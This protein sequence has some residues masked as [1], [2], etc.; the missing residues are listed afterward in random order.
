M[1][2][3]YPSKGAP[4]PADAGP[5]KE[6]LAVEALQALAELK[7]KTRH[8]FVA[9]SGGKDSIVAGHLAA[10]LDVN[11]AVRETSFNFPTAD[12]EYRRCGEEV[13][14]N[15]AEVRGC[16]EAWLATHPEWVFGP[17]RKLGGFYAVRQQA[18]VRRFA[19][20]RAMEGVVFGRRTQENTVPSALYMKAGIWQCHPLRD[21]R[22]SDVWAYI[23][24]RG[25]SYPGIYD[26]Q[27]GDYSGAA[28]WNTL[29]R[30]WLARVSD[31]RHTPE[32]LI[33]DYEPGFLE[34]IRWIIDAAEV[35]RV[36][37]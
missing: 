25:L 19:D 8:S 33:E 22:T 14:L 13:G 17:V 32:G 10:V 31:D 37:A 21:W 11:L 3:P 28:S 36:A 15:V 34:E 20:E 24:S 26:R 5:F 7:R 29:S 18:T 1:A 12:L 35:R 30:D 23:R 27:I 2:Q 16:S 9:F 4:D 6:E